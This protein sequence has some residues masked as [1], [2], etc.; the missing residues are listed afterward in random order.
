MCELF[1]LCSAKKVN[2]NEILGTFFSHGETNPDG[3]GLAVFD[4]NSANI[5]REPISAAESVY[6]KHRLAD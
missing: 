1:G 2:C 4:G 5:E 3:W 6:L